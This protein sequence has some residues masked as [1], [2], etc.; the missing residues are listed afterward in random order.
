MG[1][2]AQ[3]LSKDPLGRDKPK[4]D[5]LPPFKGFTV[6]VCPIS[7][8]PTPTSHEEALPPRC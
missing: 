7:P 8:P 4:K 5:H 2:R 3:R 1:S 6:L